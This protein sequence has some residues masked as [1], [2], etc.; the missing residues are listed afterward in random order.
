MKGRRWHERVVVRRKLG[1]N[2]QNA[3]EG[4]A[5]G[6]VIL[7]WCAV[8]SRAPYIGLRSWRVRDHRGRAMGSRSHMARRAL[9]WVAAAAVVAAGVRVVGAQGVLPPPFELHWRAPAQCPTAADV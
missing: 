4:V 7:A 5:S 2:L 3:V 8:K 6:T 9:A 1:R